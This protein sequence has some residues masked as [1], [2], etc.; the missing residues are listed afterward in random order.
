ATAR[1]QAEEAQRRRRE[2]EILYEERERLLGEAAHLEA[3]RESDRLKT[4]LLRAVSHDL[5]TPLTAM[6]LEI[7]SLDWQ[8]GDPPEAL[9]SERVLA[10][11]R[12]RP[13]R[14]ADH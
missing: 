6:R 7:E 11:E 3:M 8:L 12:A 9:A 5:R 2:V 14:R 4:S 1:R 13:A 10:L